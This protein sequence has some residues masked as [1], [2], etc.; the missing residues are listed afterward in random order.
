M[1]DMGLPGCITFAGIQLKCLIFSRVRM[2]R[3]I[4]R[5]TRFAILIWWTTC[6]CL[7]WVHWKTMHGAG[8][9]STAHRI[10]WILNRI[11][12]EILHEL[13]L[14]WTR[15]PWWVAN[16]IWC[17]TLTGILGCCNQ[18][19]FGMARI[20]C[21]FNVKVIRD[22]KLTFDGLIDPIRPIVRRLLCELNRD[23]SERSTIQVAVDYNWP[24]ATV[25]DVL[26]VAAGTHSNLLWK[27]FMTKKISSIVPCSYST[28]HCVT[29]RTWRILRETMWTFRLSIEQL[30]CVGMWTR[31]TWRMSVGTFCATVARRTTQ[32]HCCRIWR[33]IV[34]CLHSRTRNKR[35]EKIVR[36][37]E[38]LGTKNNR[39]K[40]VLCAISANRK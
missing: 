6:G 12:V 10:R 2:I 32:Q 19:T 28:M 7:S 39:K 16:R 35:E 37:W 33:W 15:S 14:R 29:P 13:M 34:W 40:S 17:I 11:I 20:K 3:W 24:M 23:Y 31:R 21:Y 38:W 26:V 18:T 4:V 25:A 8:A 30:I 1:D 36:K 9:R 5:V 22:A 27:S